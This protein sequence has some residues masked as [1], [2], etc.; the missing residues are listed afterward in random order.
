MRTWLGIGGDGGRRSLTRP[1][2]V[3]VRLAALAIAIGMTALGPVPKW[4]LLWTAPLGITMIWRAAAR[5]RLRPQPAHPV[6]EVGVETLM[7]FFAAASTGGLSSGFLLY[8]VACVAMATAEHGLA[9]SLPAAGL[10][11][12]LV[13][14]PGADGNHVARAPAATIWA[15]ELVVGLVAGRYAARVAAEEDA[16]LRRA[17]ADIDRLT[18]TNLLLGDL[19]HAAEEGAMPLDV[20]GCA[21]EI[22]RVLE[23]LLW[24]DAVVVVGLHDIDGRW[25]GEVLLAEGVALSSV[26]ELAELPAPMRTV[27]AERRPL[28][29]RVGPDAPAGQGMAATS[30]FGLYL[31]MAVGDELV[32]L[33]AV[34][35]TQD[36]P[37]DRSDVMAAEAMA[38]RAALTIDNARR[39]ARLC[40]TGLSEERT[41]LAGE[42][43]DRTGQSVAALGLQLDGII[44]RVEDPA[45]EAELRQLRASIR[46]VVAQLRDT[47]KDLRCEV[48]DSV[49]LA[50]ALQ[51]VA[52]HYCERPAVAVRSE[53]GGRLPLLHERQLYL[54]ARE[55]VAAAARAGAAAIQIDW[56]CNGER[57]VLEVA[58]DAPLCSA[59]AARYAGGAG[60]RAEIE[61]IRA[62]CEALGGSLSIVQREHGGTLLRCA[63]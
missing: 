35:S 12:L 21:R 51:R 33:I 42:L 48:S 13:L 58:D 14:V 46:S 59:P 5:T 60:R 37:W 10:L 62:R 34:E 49:D 1:A 18:N 22:E 28:L 61:T 19:C 43:H 41:R 8:A 17:E 30:R 3:A 36:A 20:V 55:A 16:A 63:V 54:V 26:V 31:P 56:R 27:V 38:A 50:Q 44:R 39:F 32:G 29:D 45:L 11:S 40:V 57:A 2:A 47:V 53:V 7:A 24:P 6:V 15:A 52:A 25:S 4:R 9:L 23:D